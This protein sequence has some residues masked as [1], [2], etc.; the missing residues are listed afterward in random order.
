MQMKNIVVIGA[1][2]AGA[3]LVA[4]LRTQ[5]HSGAITLIGA[6]PAPPYQRPP[7]SKAYLK[8]EMPAER[9]FLRPAEFYE[10]Q[11]ISLRTGQPVTAIDT[12][13][14]TVSLGADVLPYDELALTTGST[15]R[16]LPPAIGGALGGVFTL[17]DLADVDAMRPYFKAGARVVIVGGGYI[18]LEGAAVAA[19]LGL[20]VTVLEMSPRILGR[21]AAPETSAYFR[22][23]HQA[24]GVKI[25]EETGLER[26]I[27]DTHVTGAR[28]TT[29]QD[30]AADFVI[31]G[32][33]ITPETAL[34]EAAGLTLTNGIETD[35][36][37]RTSAPNVWAAGDCASFPWRGGRLRLESVQNAIDQA[38]CVAQNM[39]GAEN[40]YRPQPWF[41]SDQY[42][43]KLQIAGLNTGYDRIVTRQGEGSVS[44]WYY[45]GQTLLAVDAMNDP[46][47]FMVAKRLLEAGRSPSPE[48]VADTAVDLKTLLK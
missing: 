35:E 30:I 11:Q 28:L 34:A 21:V 19:Q 20:D 7:L 1:G 8:G 9:L 33:G 42:D 24:H 29:G 48:A 16:R 22:A 31:V 13:A 39:L 32:V 37:G 45:Q 46:R 25:L 12:A 27:G 41:W 43:T 44:F 47:A 26:L 18:G 23:L 3:S 14:Q 10:D 38:E 36:F 40:P 2:Q 6:E 5:G 15:P 17:R 4:K